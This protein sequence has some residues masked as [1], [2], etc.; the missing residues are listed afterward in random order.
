MTG[1]LSGPKYSNSD[2][3]IHRACVCVLACVRVR[4]R[5]CVFICLSVATMTREYVEIVV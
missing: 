1:K 5:V 4:V 2:E 3:F